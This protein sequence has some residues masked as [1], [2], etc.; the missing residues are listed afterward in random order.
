M[1]AGP[2]SALR[3][4]LRELELELSEVRAGLRAEGPGQPLPGL[5]LVIEA[6]GLQ[7]AL[8][9]S[10][11]DEVVPVVSFSPL[12]G[13]G[14]HVLGGFMYRG[15]PHLALDL[16]A[17][18]GRPRPV[19]LD[20]HL[21]VLSASQPVALVVDRVRRLVESPLVERDDGADEHSP[22]RSAALL[23]GMCRDA[24]VLLPLLEVGA[25]AR[26][27]VSSGEPGAGE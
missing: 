27:A 19:P 16:A 3:G 17:M 26:R 18:I 21:L 10:A 5:Y 4:R 24:D 20:A 15:A 9:A 14:S 23:E 11:V 2:R 1:A 25:L 22:W 7:A 12:P 8:P 13:A 6:N